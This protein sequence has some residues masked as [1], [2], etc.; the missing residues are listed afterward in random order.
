MNNILKE[1]PITRVPAS[2]SLRKSTADERATHLLPSLALNTDKSQKGFQRCSI[3]P[4]LLR[5]LITKLVSL[6]HSNTPQKKQ[7]P[8][9]KAAYNHKQHRKNSGKQK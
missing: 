3:P 6:L 9:F 8:L 7:K 1:S 5:A 2:P 4:H